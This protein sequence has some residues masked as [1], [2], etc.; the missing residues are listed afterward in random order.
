ML[1]RF[2]FGFWW[3]I[4][5]WRIW[6]H[7]RPNKLHVW[8]IDRHTTT[9]INVEHQFTPITFEN[10]SLLWIDSST[11]QIQLDLVQTTKTTMGL[12]SVQQAIMNVYETDY[13]DDEMER[14]PVSIDGTTLI[15]MHLKLFQHDSH[16][17]PFRR[18]EIEPKIEW[19][20]GGD[21]ITSEERVGHFKD[22]KWYE[23]ED[24]MHIGFCILIAWAV[25]LVFL[26]IMRDSKSTVFSGRVKRVF[27][28]E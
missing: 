12:V 2:V 28:N 24:P 8:H 20:L 23:G 11:D 6:Y 15:D 17:S 22:G 19:T 4:L 16:Y 13:R 10:I 27:N 5:V 7:V 21:D 25:G 9:V 14:Y 18:L 26:I 3:S 1:C